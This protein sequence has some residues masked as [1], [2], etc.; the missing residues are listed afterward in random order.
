ML[1]DLVAGDAPVDAAGVGTRLAVS[2]DAP[3]LES[4]YKLVEYDG[5]P[6]AKQST[7]KASLPGAK[8]VFRRTGLVD[9]LAL[10][11]EDGPPRAGR[12]SRP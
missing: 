10:R 3:Y 8:Q 2:D 5:R 1:A 11:E 6:V 9:T 7:G 4:V 12:C